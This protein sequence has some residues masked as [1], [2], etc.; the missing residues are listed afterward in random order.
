M[1]PTA[2]NWWANP[3]D[4]NKPARYT[5]QAHKKRARHYYSLYGGEQCGGPRSP[6]FSRP[7]GYGIYNPWILLP[8]FRGR[9]WP[10]DLGENSSAE[11]PQTAPPPSQAVTRAPPP[12]LPGL[13]L[14]HSDGPDHRDNSTPTKSGE[15]M[16]ESWSAGNRSQEMR[17]QRRAVSSP[18][19]APL[20]V[21][22]PQPPSGPLT[23]R[24]L[25]W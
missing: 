4:W 9:W 12:L 14:T 23:L 24:L 18:G 22:S 8:A 1:I 21:A 19:P 6:K 13:G 5:K 15:E 2:W 7:A 11:A 25:G 20:T 3:R 17:T 16:R 10:R